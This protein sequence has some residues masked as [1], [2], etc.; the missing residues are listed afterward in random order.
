MNRDNKTVRIPHL[1]IEM[2][3]V[4]FFEYCLDSWYLLL[5]SSLLEFSTFLKSPI[6]PI[7]YICP[8]SSDQTAEN[9]NLSKFVGHSWQPQSNRCWLREARRWA[10]EIIF[11]WPLK[12]D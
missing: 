8:L 12:L 3:G 9:C 10:Q 2:S 4:K 7:R 6:L 11:I 1:D 5:Y